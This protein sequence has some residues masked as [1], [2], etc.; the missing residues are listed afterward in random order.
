MRPISYYKIGYQGETKLLTQLR[1][2]HNQVIMGIQR[3]VHWWVLGSWISWCPLLM[4]LLLFFHFRSILFFSSETRRQ[5]QKGPKE[6]E[7]ERE[8]SDHGWSHV[9]HSN[10][11]K[12]EYLCFFGLTLRERERER[13][14]AL[15]THRPTQCSLLLSFLLVG[16]LSCWV[17]VMDLLFGTQLRGRKQAS[18][19]FEIVCN[20]GLILLSQESNWEEVKWSE[21]IPMI[22]TRW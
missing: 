7:R 15:I 11:L 3:M 14:R 1:F 2:I 5:N 21:V 13:E 16:Q 8:R 19:G 10:F 17:R 18:K 12:R 4:I 22:I 6:R 9:H 20:V